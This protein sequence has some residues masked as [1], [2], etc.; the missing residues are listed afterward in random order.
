MEDGCLVVPDTPGS[1]FDVEPKV[2]EEGLEVG[3][4]RLTV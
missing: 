3:G 1:G 2:F 4:F